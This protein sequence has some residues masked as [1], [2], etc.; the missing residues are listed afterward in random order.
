MIPE[1]YRTSGK[2]TAEVKALVRGAVKPGMGFLE[3]C[4]MVRREVE[5]RGGGLAFPTGIGVNEV[6]AHYA[7][8]VGD[9]SVVHDEDLVKV[10]FGVHVDGYVTDTSVTL[11]FNPEYNL[12]LEATERCLE[13]AMETVRRDPRTA[14]VGREIHREAARFG[15]KTIENLTGHTV[16]RYV[17]HAGKSIPNL[18]M[19]G[20]QSLK[21]GEVFAIEPFLTLGSAAGYVV[22]TPSKTI[23]SLVARKKTGFSELD[24]FAEKIWAERKTLPFTPRWYSPEYPKDRLYD[25]LNKLVARKVVRAYPTLVEASGS[26]VAQFE[27]TMALDESGLVVLT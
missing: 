17:V 6:T 18:Y 20:M 1:Q 10:D 25:I 12:L 15:F 26:P 21:K 24:A 16:D 7:P 23:F 9:E 19:P 13:T 11:T 22:D 4:D 3:I 5:R 8:Q 27:H 2:I 14:E